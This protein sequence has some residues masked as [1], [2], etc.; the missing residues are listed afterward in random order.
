[1]HSLDGER[2]SGN[3]AITDRLIDDIPQI[4]DC[5]KRQMLITF[6]FWWLGTYDGNILS[7]SHAHHTVLC[8]HVTQRHC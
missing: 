7:A 5:K 6:Y 1:M 4:Y 8:T 3:H 2:L